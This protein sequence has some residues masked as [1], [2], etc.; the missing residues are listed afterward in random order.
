MNTSAK[1]ANQFGMSD[2]TH[3]ILSNSNF[4]FWTIEM[5]EGAHPR[6]YGDEKLIKLLDISGGMSPEDLYDA[7]HGRVDSSSYDSLEEGVKKLSKGDFVEVQYIWHHPER[8]SIYIRCC[9]TRNC[10]YADGLKFE[11]YYQ[12]ITNL[13]QVQENAL[14]QQQEIEKAKLF[15]EEFVKQY[16]WA[17]YVNIVD[18]SMIVYHRKSEIH[19]KYGR[20]KDYHKLLKMYIENDV[21]SDDRKMMYTLVDPK[22]IREYMKQN[23]DYSFVLRDISGDYERHFR[24]QVIRGRDEEHVAMSF[25]DVSE[26]IFRET[27]IEHGHKIIQALSA[28]YTIVFSAD[29]LADESRVIF[30][31]DHYAKILQTVDPDV[32]ENSSFSKR[33]RAIGDTLV[34]PEDRD[35][36]LRETLPENLRTRFVKENIVFIE[37]RAGFGDKFNHLMMKIVPSSKDAQDNVI[38]GVRNVENEYIAKR[39]AEQE[40]LRN[41]EI[42][43]AL[44]S[45]YS[46]VY[47]VNID[48]DELTSYAMNLDDE[49]SYNEI[50]REDTPYSDAFKMYAACF[51]CDKDRDRVL[52]DGLIPNIQ[53]QLAAKKSFSIIYQNVLNHY[54]EMRFV[55][56][57]N[58]DKPS[59]VAIGF[60]D[61]NEELREKMEREKYLE[62]ANALSWDFD[63]IYYVNIETGDYDE[64]DLQ[65]DFIRMDVLKLGGRFFE[66]V[67][68]VIPKVVYQDDQPA[69]KN[70]MR[71]EFLLRQLESKK[72]FTYEYRRFS[73]GEIVHFRLKALRPSQNGDHLIIAI[74]NIESEVQERENRQAELEQN[75]EIIEALASEYSSVYYIDL[76]ADRI[77]PY[78]MNQDTENA[79]GEIFR[80]EITYSKAM[81][82]YARKFICNKDRPMMLVASSLGN[83]KEKLS[84]KK[85]F[86]TIYRN[87]IDRYCEMKFV[88]VGDGSNPSYA[89]LGFVDRDDELR[90]DMEKSKYSE[91]A[92]ALSREY[93]SIYYVSLIDDS[94]DEFVLQGTYT[95]L[96]L[97]TTGKNFFDESR[98]NLKRVAHPD[99]FEKMESLFH[100]GSLLP[101]LGVGK[102]FTKEYRLI[103]CGKTVYYRLKALKTAENSDH[104]IIAVANIDES[105][106]ERLKRQEELER[107]VQIIDVLASEY[108]SVYYINL[109]TGSLTPYT[110]NANT[111]SK[112]GKVSDSGVDYSE[113]FKLYVEK[114]VFENDKQMML[115]AGSIENIKKQLKCQKNYVTTYRSDK[116]GEL[117]YCEMKFVKVGNEDDEPKAV[118]L[119]FADR[120]TE[121][122]NRYVDSKL[123][124]DYIGMYFVNLEDNLIRCI[125]QSQIYKA[126]MGYV[127]SV[128][129]DRIA[130]FSESVMPEYQEDWKKMANIEYVQKYLAKEDKREYNYRALAG[131]W[132]RCTAI[133]LERKNGVPVS[134]VLTFMFIDN[135]T[136]QKLELD[137]KIAKQKKVLE[138]QQVLLEQALNRA[139][140][141]SRAKTTFLSNM[142]HDIRTPMN[143][144][145]GFTNLAMSCSSDMEKVQ[146]YL[147]KTAVSSQHLLSLINDILDMSRI[148]S[149]KIQ[150][151]CVECDLV[152]IM[153]D[154]N[155]IILGQAQAKQLNLFMDSFDVVDEKV[156]C[157]KLRLHQ[158]LIN[159]LSNAIKFTP[160]KGDVYLGIRQVS[161][162][163]NIAEFEFIV[164]DNGIGMSEDFLK[165][166]Y[167]PFE[168]E[169]S[170]TISRTQGTGLGM[171]ITKNIVDMMGGTID[172]KSEPGKGTEYIVRLTMELQKAGNDII[173]LE[174]LKNKKALVVDDDNNSCT[175][176]KSLLSHLGMRVDCLNY[177]KDAVSCARK[178]HGSEDAYAV[179]VI[180]WLM[181]DMNGIEVT[182][183]LRSVV[184]KDIPIIVMTAYDWTN[185]EDEASAA[186]VTSFISKPLFLS[187]MNRTLA[188]AMGVNIENVQG[189]SLRHAKFEGKKILLVEDNELNREIAET[190]LEDSGFIVDMAENGAIALEKIKT[191]VSGTYD[192]VLMDVQMPVMDGYEATRAIRKLEDKTKASV[193]IIA[194]TANAFAEDRKAT[195]EAGMNE[196]V[197]KPIDVEKLKITLKK[198]L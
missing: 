167:E 92:N 37:F 69:L 192:L 7:W 171:S 174:K 55:K 188:I 41:Y 8:E 66:E 72:V 177:G 53:K 56:V 108:S 126:G 134:M 144:I 62:I 76:T 105:V 154:L 63:C 169:H 48:T 142:S 190:L 64:F 195:L 107:N 58:G 65:G 77:V 139:E 27:E 127:T 111:E 30:M 9:G 198:F 81:E 97:N 15:S 136:A 196:H 80:G 93:E 10:G 117:H 59:F 4:G 91:I 124:E 114:M 165:K 113:V 70:V 106:R 101:L 122:L 50:F 28:D 170:S 38:V 60:A 90:D 147:A 150:L 145:I 163:G 20:E 16:V 125:K 112:L 149:G 132:R 13:V 193:P 83:I 73:D 21:H 109:E 103:I 99:D 96:N 175:S 162:N 95:K 186:G 179:Y 6:L 146:G 1:T 155:T 102:F 85:S 185:I 19:N 17:C 119:V 173:P 152:E 115:N 51:V 133:V 68:K 110:I 24:F 130:E 138:E 79:F 67:M 34:H 32:R 82:M 22:Y 135:I 116:E 94:Y 86:A 23:K 25:A 183:Q 128:Y 100:K 54:C 197:S 131:E 89:A 75:F 143:A 140:S 46:S 176:A 182:R 39:N 104:V 5:D 29:L 31:T 98:E 151:E 184:D 36:F 74:A 153:H 137:D 160:V 40:R 158:V 148:E 84:E 191:A 161:R 44:S 61:R 18:H 11:G 42:I 14:V 129:T 123:Y 157:D 156:V 166:L 33:M 172:V 45:D 180:D 120:D 49:N 187:E 118:T 57:G 47:Y 78:T 71:K 87:A 178:V 88:K 164:K 26:D 194:M 12:D 168:R 189:T 43:E 181:P 141:A 52:Y 3:G 159:L 2:L 35:Y 121:I